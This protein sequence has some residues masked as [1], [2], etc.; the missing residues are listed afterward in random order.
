MVQLPSTLLII[1]A[2]AAC[3]SGT[4]SVFNQRSYLQKAVGRAVQ[5]FM[6]SAGAVQT[7]QIRFNGKNWA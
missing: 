7:V 5:L 6:H 2:S 4:Q 1:W 3:L